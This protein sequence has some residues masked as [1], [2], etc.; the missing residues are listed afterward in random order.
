MNLPA[1]SGIS[2][3]KA[4]GRSFQRNQIW[5]KTQSLQRNRIWEKYDQGQL[6]SFAI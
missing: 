2:A 5:E 1:L 6:L 4:L 3:W